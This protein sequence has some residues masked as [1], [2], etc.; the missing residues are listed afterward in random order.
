[1][2]DMQARRSFAVEMWAKA[3]AGS[4]AAARH[5]GL[6]AV[7]SPGLRLAPRGG[8]HRIAAAGLVLLVSFAAAS[9]SA[10]ENPAP[11]RPA[12]TTPPP[13]SVHRIG[14][15]LGV[16]SALGEAGATYT[17]Y[18]SP[19]LCAEAGIGTGVTGLQLS[20]MPKL[21]LGQFMVGAGLSFS[22]GEDAHGAT[23][24]VFWVNLD[25]LGYEFCW[26]A[27]SWLIVAGATIPL[28]G[29]HA[30]YAELGQDIS[31]G[32]ILAQGRTSFGWRF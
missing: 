12:P 11:A 14:I 6:S 4:A 25:A 29:L 24:Q 8:V 9:A 7:F 18:P 30:D 16:A 22:R 31:A 19:W 1:M 15:D 28:R 27:F 26:G 21:L 17:Y 3:D 13:A 5:R 20:L 2:W 10:S 32:E 23:H